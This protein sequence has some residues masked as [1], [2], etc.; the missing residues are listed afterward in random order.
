ML[1][2]LIGGKFCVW[3]GPMEN[4]KFRL[5]GNVFHSK[6]NQFPDGTRVIERFENVVCPAGCTAQKTSVKLC[7]ARQWII[8]SKSPSNLTGIAV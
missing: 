5:N 1:F 2:T 4:V 8:H 3:D 7:S 6:S